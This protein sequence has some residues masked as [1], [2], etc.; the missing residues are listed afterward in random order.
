MNLSFEYN[1]RTKSILVIRGEE[2]NVLARIAQA[3][4]LDLAEISQVFVVDAEDGNVGPLSIY[5]L[6]INH[7]YK[8]IVFFKIK[9]GTC[10]LKSGKLRLFLKIDF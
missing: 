9:N 1:G 7:E 4:E 3:F 10:C 2:Q 6:K 5:T 8:L